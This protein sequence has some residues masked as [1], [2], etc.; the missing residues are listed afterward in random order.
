MGAGE[1]M[2]NLD[3]ISTRSSVRKS[4]MREAL[5]DHAEVVRGMTI[6]QSRILKLHASALM[7]LKRIY[8]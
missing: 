4:D 1:K 5:L 6:M 7:M 8:P 2:L 3:G